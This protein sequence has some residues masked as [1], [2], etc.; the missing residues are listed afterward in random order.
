MKQDQ[1]IVCGSRIFFICFV[2]CSMQAV[3]IG[4][5]VTPTGFNTQQ[6]LM[7]GDRVA[8]FASLQ[9]GFKL[10]NSSVSAEFDSFFQVAG[11]IDL[12]GGRL[13]LGRDMIIHNFANIV[14]LGDITGSEHTIEF[15]VTNTL[16]PTDSDGVDTCFTFSEVSVRLN[17]NMMLQD[18]CI[19][20]EGDSVING[21]GNCLTLADTCTLQVDKD[22]TL[23]LKDVT[24]KGLNS[25]KIACLDSLS[26][27]TLLNVKC[28]LDGDY[29]FTI[30]HF[31]V[32][33]DFHVC[34]E[35][36]TLAYQSNQ[37]STVQEYGNII[38]DYGVTF[39]YDPSIAS[40]EL[41]DLVS[42]TSMIEL[43]GGTLHATKV[44]MQLKKGV[45]KIDRRSTL[46]SEGSVIA[47]A[48]SLG[49]GL[50]VANNIDVQILPSAQ[51]VIEGPVIDND[52]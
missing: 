42:D 40:Q 22:S 13:I 44:G 39:S 20:F 9:G 6:I 41:I 33:K 47:E 4:S 38:I 37:V 3:D 15:A 43:R 28:I 36:H 14:R 29:S 7:N 8:G 18:C 24:I 10:N 45:L 31:D 25:N 11:N 35:G 49:D 23:L 17:C 46:S 1:S 2:F 5:D 50:D 52:V 30:G 21:G 48:I 32:V 51:L 34:G 27:I 26:T 16:V 19:I 12:N